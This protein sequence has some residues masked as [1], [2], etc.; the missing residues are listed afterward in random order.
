MSANPNEAIKLLPCGKKSYLD[1]AYAVQ[2]LKKEKRRM[3]KNRLHVYRCPQ[4]G[5]W[6]L[7]KMSERKKAGL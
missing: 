2:V 1:R 6:H 3:G 5:L 7:G 4:C